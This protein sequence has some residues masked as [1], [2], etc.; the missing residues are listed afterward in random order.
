MSFKLSLDF[1]LAFGDG[2]GIILK[3]ASKETEHASEV[4]LVVKLS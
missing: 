1:G 2:A 3:L 4:S